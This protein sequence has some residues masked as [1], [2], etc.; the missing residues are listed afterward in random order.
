M[1]NDYTNGE[2]SQLKNTLAAV[3]DKKLKEGSRAGANSS[4]SPLV[5]LLK[6]GATLAFIVF[7]LYSGLMYF[8]KN[9]DQSFLAKTAQHEAIFKETAEKFARIS[10]PAETSG[11]SKIDVFSAR[12]LIIWSKP[13]ADNRLVARINY[14]MPEKRQAAK[15]Q[16]TDLI[17]RL[18][19]KKDRTYISKGKFNS[20]FPI[21]DIV[22][23]FIDPK[24]S[25]I[26]KSHM[27]A[28]DPTENQSERN[29]LPIG[30]MPIHRVQEFLAKELGYT[31]SFSWH[32][33]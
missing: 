20:K 15:P 11:R 3:R 24:T 9:T 31:P 4:A 25:S 5:P 10:S 18:T 17:V 2:I 16:E 12:T 29:R 27:I 7:V 14:N 13:D 32:T 19:V 21:Y 23:D 8:V 1:T 30:A 33:I 22:A 26:F 28:G 6:A